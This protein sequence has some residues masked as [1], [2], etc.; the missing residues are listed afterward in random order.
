[1]AWYRYKFRHGPGHQGDHEEYRWYDYVP[2]DAE[3]KDEMHEIAHDRHIEDWFCD[4]DPVETLPEQVREEFIRKY[5]G[6]IRHGQEMLKVL[7][8]ES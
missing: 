4:C 2:S 8:V 6:Y 7:G 3:Q 1:M 5:K